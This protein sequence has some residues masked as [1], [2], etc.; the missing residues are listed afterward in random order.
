MVLVNVFGTPPGVNMPSVLI[1][2]P[3]PTIV[4][5][6]VKVTTAP[7]SSRPT[8][9]ICCLPF[10]VM[11]CGFGEIEIVDSSPGLLILW[12]SHDATNSP[13][14]ATA[15]TERANALLFVK[16]LIQPPDL[17]MWARSGL[18]QLG[19]AVVPVCLVRD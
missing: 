5:V 18:T 15:P 14:M 4:H 13:A 10:T 8:A 1:A 16:L 17:C 19:I 11:V 12:T 6:G 2:P 3:P 7:S 9:V